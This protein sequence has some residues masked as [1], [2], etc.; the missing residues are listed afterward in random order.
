MVKQV[1]GLTLDSGGHARGGRSKRQ[2]SPRHYRDSRSD[3]SLREGCSCDVCAGGAL[4]SSWESPVNNM[5]P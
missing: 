1:M 5:I 3:E 2:L 4:A